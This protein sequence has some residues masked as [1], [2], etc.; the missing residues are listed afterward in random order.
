MQ[1]RIFLLAAMAG[2]RRHEAD[3]LPW[4]ALNTPTSIPF[5][6]SSS[7]QAARA[8]LQ[9]SKG[10]LRWPT[11]SGTGEEDVPDN[12]LVRRPCFALPLIFGFFA[13]RN[14]TFPQLVLSLN[15]N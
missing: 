15:F 4:S 1:Y 13:D 12:L 10:S 8:P 11:D 3:L 2:L 9:R 14:R 6:R 7:G 5:C